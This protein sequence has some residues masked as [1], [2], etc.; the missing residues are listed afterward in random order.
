[1]GR[2][3]VRISAVVA[4]AV[5]ILAGSAVVVYRVLSP[6]EQLTR[7]TVAYP[8][9]V[10]VTDERPFSE[11]RAA[12]LV[13]EGRL[14][15]YA[16]KW[17]VWS[18]SPVGE[19][20]ESTP[21]WAF[22]RWPAQVVG[23]VAAQAPTGPTVIT[24]WSDGQVI[25][26]DA[27]RGAVAWRTEA[28]ANGRL[29]D[30]RRTG[31]SVV[32]QPRSLLTARSAA[33]PVVIVTSPG[34]VVAYDA[35]SGEP[36]WRHTGASDCEPDGWTGH[37]VVVLPDCAG[38]TLNLVQATD[39]TELATWRS[40]AGTAARPELCELGRAECRLAT[41]GVGHW[42]LNANGS[43]APVPAPPP[44]AHLAGEAVVYPI[45]GGVSAARISDGQP[46]WSWTGQGRLVAADA[47]GVYLL[48]EDGTVLGLSARTGHLASV[49]CANGPEDRPWK[50][51]HTYPA[52]GN[53]LALERITGEAPTVDDQRYFY[54]PRPIALVELY[55]PT[56]LPVWPGKFASCRRP[57]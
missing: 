47:A 38:T 41:D 7:P 56:K 40:P 50:I 30:G 44:G 21:Y 39:G 22:R 19:R 53:Y 4:A 54:G 33:G 25:A 26:L 23:V 57:V 1:M 17:R 35:T 6:H 37:G 3:A 46:V 31:A 28:P 42:A 12:P 48:A 55:A 43:L 20:Y 16:E 2:R 49:G 52:T 10:I 45:P 9:P 51:G 36:L 27:R 24:Q 34:L 14:R 32:Y 29:Y 15:V 8:E 18:D 13:I 5:L 11:L